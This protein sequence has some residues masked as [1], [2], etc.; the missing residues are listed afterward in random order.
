MTPMRDHLTKLLVA[1][2]AVLILWP[3]VAHAQ[4]RGRGGRGGGPQPGFV[5]AGVP[6]MPNPPGPAPTHDL[7]GTW[8]GPISVV[9]GPYPP[10]TPA[11]QAARALNSKIPRASDVGDQMVP[12]NDPFAICDPLGIPRVLLAH[13]LSSRGGIEFVPAA[14]R[15]LMLFEHQ[16]VWREIWMDGRQLPAKVDERGA[17]D[18]RFYGY[19]VGRWEADNVF[20]IDTVGLDSRS[21]LEEAGLP[22]TNAAKLQERWR[23]VDQYHL[24]ATVTVNDPQYYTQPF[25]LMKNVYYWKKDQNVAEELCL[26]SEALEYNGRLA[27]PSGF[28]IANKP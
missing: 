9:M 11:G 28:G 20:V 15:M 24:E 26:P 16:R 2:L 8:V 4:G 19:S 7:T 22:H 23:R 12:N 13:W 1:S 14:N 6:E 25:Q 3:A 18:A 27:A 21:W 17:P 10:M 5:A